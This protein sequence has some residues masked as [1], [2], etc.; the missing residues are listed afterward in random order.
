MSNLSGIVKIF[1]MSLSE[2]KSYKIC[3]TSVSFDNLILLLTRESERL[4]TEF[5]GKLLYNSL[6]FNSKFTKKA[7][8]FGPEFLESATKLVENN[9]TP[10]LLR[11]NL[12]V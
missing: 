3:N 7:L 10:P 2:L 12:F 1:W 11:K 9:L 5:S 4:S 6:H 8:S